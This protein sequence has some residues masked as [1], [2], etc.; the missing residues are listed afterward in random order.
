VEIFGGVAALYPPRVAIAAAFHFLDELFDLAGAIAQKASSAGTTT[1]TNYGKFWLFPRG[2]I[3]YPIR[4]D[5]QSFC[6]LLR[7]Q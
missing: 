5:V 3:P 7:C 1:E 4:G 6:N 2:V